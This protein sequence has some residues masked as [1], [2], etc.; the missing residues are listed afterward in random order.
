MTSMD[1]DNDWLVACLDLLHKWFWLWGVLSQA[2]EYNRWFLV[3]RQSWFCET[4]R[5]CYWKPSTVSWR[6]FFEMLFF[7]IMIL[8]IMWNRSFKEKSQRSSLKKR[9]VSI[10]WCRNGLQKS[11]IP[12]PLYWS[13]QYFDHLTWSFLNLLNDVLCIFRTLIMFSW[14]D[15]HI[16][17][18]AVAIHQSE[19]LVRNL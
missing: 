12:T 7:I 2:E 1:L 10:E 15:L 16:C 8:C 5:T 14:S 13:A 9:A 18:F 19:N 3:S 4:W 17:I 11:V 6:H